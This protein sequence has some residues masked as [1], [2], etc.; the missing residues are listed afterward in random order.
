MTIDK[1]KS[2]AADQSTQSNSQNVPVDSIAESVASVN[3]KA[4]S[5]YWVCVMY[6]EN[7][8][9]N[10][11]LLIGDLLQGLPYAY[12]LHHADHDTKSEHRKD[13][14]HL[15]VV[16]ANTTTYKHAMDVFGELNAPG[17]RAFNTCQQVHSIRGQYDYLIHDTETCRKQ[18]KEQYPKESRVTGNNFD[19]GAYEQVG[20]AEK[21]AI[22]KELAQIAIEN[23]FINFAD[24]FQFVASEYA[25]NDTYFEILLS[26]SGFF[27]RL[28]K[29]NYQKWQVT[30]E[31][32]RQ[33]NE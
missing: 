24:F 3:P 11:E 30:Q 17:K 32:R 9:Q 5:R 18:G 26:Y 2:S 23:K 28:T 6:V 25:D 33:M 21:R 31:I 27:E 29:G 10:W 8:V 14:I 22:C 7:M 4:K 16:F 13:H 12:C 1:K 15:I 19:I 20:I